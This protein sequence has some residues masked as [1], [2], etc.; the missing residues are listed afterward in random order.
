MKTLALHVSFFYRESRLPYLHRI[1]DETKRYP[2][3]TDVFIHC[4]ERLDALEANALKDGIK[5]VTICHELQGTN[6]YEICRLHRGL[7]KIQR[8]S[9]DYFALIED[10]ILVPAAALAYWDLHRGVVMKEGYN[11]GFMRVDTDDRGK[12]FLTDVMGSVFGE[13]ESTLVINGSTY[14]LNNVNPY[15]AF[16][17]YDKLEFGRFVDSCYWNPDNVRGY[18]HAV[19]AAIGLHG[20]NTHWYNGTLVP[21][22]EGSLLPECRIHHLPSNYVKDTRS[23]FATIPFGAVNIGTEV[24]PK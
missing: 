11:L 3:R 10:D 21:F 13:L 17:I 4:N 12:D 14:L 9:Y 16:W 19:S 24:P 6:K 2:W 5:V 15:C 20:L 23:L 22:A 8:H 7:M 18:D 1:L